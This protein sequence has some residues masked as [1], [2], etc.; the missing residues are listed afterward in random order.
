MNRS[1]LQWLVVIRSGVRVGSQWLTVGLQFL[2]VARSSV[3]LGR[4]FSQ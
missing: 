4:S 3:Q 1:G 2:A